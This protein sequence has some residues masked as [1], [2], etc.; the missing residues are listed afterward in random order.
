M[1]TGDDT[2]LVLLLL[3][4]WESRMRLLE[5]LEK[6]AESSCGSYCVHT[7]PHI[8]QT[9]LR[10]GLFEFCWALLRRLPG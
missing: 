7:P 9:E 1:E 10:A 2:H 6:S 3:L 5:M 8:S 4:L